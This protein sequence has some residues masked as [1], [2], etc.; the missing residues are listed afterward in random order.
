MVKNGKKKTATPEGKSKTSTE[1][2]CKVKPKSKKRMGEKNTNRGTPHSKM[3]V[4]LLHLNAVQTKQVIKEQREELGYIKQYRSTLTS[5]IT[6]FND[7]S[8][9]PAHIRCLKKT[10]FYYFVMQFADKKV[11]AKFVKC[12]QIGTAQLLLA[13]DK[14]KDKF[15]IGG[16]EITITPEECQLIFGINP[17]HI[18]INTNKSSKPREGLAQRK[19]RDHVKLKRK[20][21]KPELMKCIGNED[22]ESV[23]DVVRLIILYLVTNFFVTSGSLVGWWTFKYCEDIDMMSQY[24]WGKAITEFFMSSVRKDKAIDV[25]GC[26]ALLLFW[27]CERTNIVSPARECA[28]PRFQRWNLRTLSE[29]LRNIA[30]MDIPTKDVHITPLEPSSKEKAVLNWY[31]P[32]ETQCTS[33]SDDVVEDSV[34]EDSDHDTTNSDTDGGSPDIGDAHGNADDSPPHDPVD[35]NPEIHDLNARGC[36]SE[37]NM[38]TRLAILEATVRQYETEINDLKDALQSSKSEADELRTKVSN[39]QAASSNPDLHVDRLSSL[40][41]KSQHELDRRLTVQLNEAYLNL[42]NERQRNL[43]LQTELVK[44]KADNERLLMNN[45]TTQ[46]LQAELT[47]LKTCNESLQSAN[48]NLE[49]EISKLRKQTTSGPASNNIPPSRNDT[50]S[51]ELLTPTQQ[52]SDDITL[53]NMPVSDLTIME[54][55]ATVQVMQKQEL[56]AKRK[57]TEHEHTIKELTTALDNCTKT[58]PVLDESDDDFEEAGPSSKKQMR[59][60]NSVVANRTRSKK[61]HV[62]PS[63]LKTIPKPR[64][65]YKKYTTYKNLSDEDKETINSLA[66]QRGQVDTIIWRPPDSNQSVLS[67]DLFALIENKSIWS[68]FIDCYCMKLS[69][70]QSNGLFDTAQSEDMKGTSIVLPSML[71]Y[72]LRSSGDKTFVPPVHLCAHRYLIFPLHSK[73]NKIKKIDHWTLL[74]FDKLLCDWRFYNSLQ[75][76]KGHKDAYLQDAEDMV[77]NI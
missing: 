33:N 11:D 31:E 62:T 70:D 54:L 61:Q 9:R 25:K 46:E 42:Q 58:I 16:E 38:Q 27:F 30:I 67:N 43:D 6:F 56:V 21:L 15:I 40:K 18:E 74:V 39:I 52:N 75:P 8:L 29:S 73:G 77:I 60:P 37:P 13:F 14:E 19:F 45:A 47:V 32:T 53:T 28:F 64:N 24:N 69:M 44:V 7:I 57:I 4:D 10:P 68:S 65:S 49:E 20:Y 63:T 72:C 5:T 48:T 51:F 1:T 55:Q 35:H 17:G 26:R 59:G 2:V 12:T 23:E 22:Q 71:L 66:S 76:R 34:S 41:A 50:P 3:K 36:G